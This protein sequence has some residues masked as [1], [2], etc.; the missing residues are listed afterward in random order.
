LREL[1]PPADW[2]EHA[3]QAIG[4]LLDNQKLKER[5]AEIEAVIQRMDFRWDQGFI[6]DKEEYLQKRLAL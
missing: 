5:V 3:V 1:K 4:D 6:T 2:K